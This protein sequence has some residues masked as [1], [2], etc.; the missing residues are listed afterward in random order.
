MATAMDATTTR[1]EFANAADRLAHPFERLVHPIMP[2]GAR[3]DA[4]TTGYLRPWPAK[5]AVTPRP[6]NTLPVM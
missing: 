1:P 2:G 3:T 6:M 4:G 5:A